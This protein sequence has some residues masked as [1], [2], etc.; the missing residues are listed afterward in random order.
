MTISTEDADLAHLACGMTAGSVRELLAV[1]ACNTP[2][3]PAFSSAGGGRELTYGALAALSGQW[4][5]ALRT[6]RLPL[7]ARIGLWIDEPLDFIGTYL[8]CLAAGVTVVPFNPDAPVEDVERNARRLRLDLVATDRPER[9]KSGTVWHIQAG[10]PQIAAAAA[11]EPHGA[12]DRGM[13]IAKRRLRR[14]LRG[15]AGGLGRRHPDASDSPLPAA[16][17]RKPSGIRI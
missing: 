13:R 17:R 2:E 6:A 4:K 10:R 7:E 5:A 12:F 9:L 3:R 1:R 15:R 11:S 16:F 8:S 14:R